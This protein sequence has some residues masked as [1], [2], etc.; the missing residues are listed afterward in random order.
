MIG[1]LVFR[2]LKEASNLFIKKDDKG[3]NV[4]LLTEDYYEKRLGDNLVTI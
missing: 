3:R 4:V 2:E 1:R